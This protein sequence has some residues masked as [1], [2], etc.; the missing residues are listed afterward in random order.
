MVGKL[1]ILPECV[2]PHPLSNVIPGS[3]ARL[4]Q[5]DPDAVCRV[6]DSTIGAGDVRAIL[7]QWVKVHENSKL[8]KVRFEIYDS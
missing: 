6:V 2:L 1:R 3:Y 8:R 4:C 5:P 7:S